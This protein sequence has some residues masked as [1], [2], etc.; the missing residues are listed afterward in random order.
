MSDVG[1]A[2]AATGRWRADDLVL[3]YPCRFPTEA[4]AEGNAPGGGEQGYVKAWHLR[5]Q[6]D[7]PT[8]AAKECPFMMEWSI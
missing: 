2:S 1:K 4:P 6:G 8:P 7:K 3:E 5:T